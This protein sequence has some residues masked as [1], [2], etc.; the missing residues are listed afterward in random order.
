LHASKCGK[1]AFAMNFHLRLKN[2]NKN[3][4]MLCKQGNLKLIMWTVMMTKVG[5]KGMSTYP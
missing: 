4:A 1:V 2:K 3:V 5:L